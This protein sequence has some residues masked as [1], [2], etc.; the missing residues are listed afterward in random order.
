MQR[1][2]QKDINKTLDKTFS[3]QDRPSRQ[4][5]EKHRSKKI[6]RHT[7]RHSKTKI[8]KK[9]KNIKTINKKKKKNPNVLDKF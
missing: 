2:T 4:R 7:T 5:Y 8:H 3:N 6:K 1:T 9:K